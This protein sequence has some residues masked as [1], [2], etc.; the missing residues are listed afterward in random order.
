MFGARMPR[1]RKNYEP[2]DWGF[3]MERIGRALGKIYRQPKRM[4]RQL[5]SVVTQLER[6]LP[7]SRGRKKG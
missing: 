7:K 2:T 6:K 1:R 5:R 4:P 3:T